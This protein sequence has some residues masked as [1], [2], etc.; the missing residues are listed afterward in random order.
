MSTLVKKIKMMG[1]ERFN[2]D[3][4][5]TGL[6]AYTD[7]NSDQLFRRGVLTGTTI[8]MVTVQEDVKGAEAIK[9]LNDS[10]TYQ[11]ANDCSMTADGDSTVFTDR[12]I[13]SV[14]QG[15]YKTFCQDDLSGFWT[16]LALKGGAMAENETLIFEEELMNYVLELHSAALESLLWTGDTSGADLIDGWAVQMDAD[17][18]I[19]NGNSAGVTAMS[20]SNAYAAFLAT[21]RALPVAVRKAEDKVI[22][23]GIEYFD[24][25]KDDL[26]SQNLFHVMVENT[27]DDTLILPA[28]GVRVQRVPGLDG[29]NGLYAGRRSDFIYGTA[30]ESDAGSVEMW[31]DKDDDLIK[32]RNK[33]YAGV[34]YPFSNQIVKWTPAAS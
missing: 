30:L 4:D 7:E 5:T 2:F 17:A 6:T 33:F 19:P 28:T 11:A 8:S 23:C 15:F 24:F 18:V 10:I 1:A 14:K 3:F 21:A 25:L 12:T 29:H 27:E 13:T 22:F 9:L 32:I 31:Y 34:S 26:F 20:A 16:R